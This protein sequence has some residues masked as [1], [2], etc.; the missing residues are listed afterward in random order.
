[1]SRAQELKM[2]IEELNTLLGQAQRQRSKDLLGI[3]VRKLQ[4]ELS[5][6]SES[7]TQDSKSSVVS[8]DSSSKCY[9]VK[10]NNYGWDQSDKF[11]KIYVEVKNVQ[12]LPEGAVTC[13]FTEK[14]LDLWAM[15]LENRNYHMP[16]NNLCE[17]IDV[18]KS[19]I[20]VKT[21]SIVV[22][23]AKKI[24]NKNWSYVTGV[25]KR[26]KEA[27]SAPPTDFEKGQDP[28]DSLMNLMKKMYQDGDDKMKKIIA[29]A[30]TESQEK[31]SNTLPDFNPV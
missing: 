5:K 1:M 22:F 16:I 25:E 14:S 4:T 20:K 12:S 27:K 26:I 15:G 31:K 21:D 23:L 19:Y 13:K 10:L 17:D 11:V 29:K 18:S 30:W 24:P 3:E 7:H 8:S 9:E 2:D 6:F 28:E